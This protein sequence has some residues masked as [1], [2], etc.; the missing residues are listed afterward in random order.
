MNICTAIHLEMVNMVSIMHIL[1]TASGSDTL[2]KGQ[3]L[4]PVLLIEDPDLLRPGRQEL[5]MGTFSQERPG[6]QI[7]ENTVSL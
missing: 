2:N 3:P 1:N 4:F 7:E 5:P 6:I